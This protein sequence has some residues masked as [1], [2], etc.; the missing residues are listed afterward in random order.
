MVD[1]D[2]VFFKNPLPLMKCDDC[3]LIIQDHAGN[4]LVNPG[5]LLIKPT[6][7]GKALCRKLWDAHL[8][9]Y[10]DDQDA[11]NYIIP[12]MIKNNEL[13]IQILDKRFA[14]GPVYFGA[15]LV[16]RKSIDGF[17][18]VHNTFIT[19]KAR[20][21]FRFK[22]FGLWVV[23]ERYYYSNPNSKY[24][25]YRNDN[26][27]HH[28]NQEVVNSHEREAVKTAFVIGHILKRIVIVP[29]G[30]I[31]SIKQP[32]GCD[33]GERF[34]LWL[35][36][37]TMPDSYRETNFLHNDLVPAS[38]KKSQSSTYLIQAGNI[39]NDANIPAG[40]LTLMKPANA[41]L[42]SQEEIHQW[43]DKLASM[44]VLK[45]HSL[46]FS[47]DTTDDKFARESVDRVFSN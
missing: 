24:L 31:C 9:N 35:L 15:D 16:Q 11:I 19:T 39:Y 13:K 44:S 18:T 6:A 36:D 43:F 14:D 30:F 42:V 25:I 8:G 26:I 22:T 2:I 20:K 41:L 34:P 4:Q 10:A 33:F 47:V 1:T 46:Y 32:W 21:I 29:A 12:P 38:V 40:N 5:F 27:R 17:I 28:G 7:A 37:K 45:F 23:N 3:D